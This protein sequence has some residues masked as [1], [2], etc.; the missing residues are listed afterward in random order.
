MCFSGGGG[1]NQMMQMYLQQQQADQQAALQRELSDKQLAAQRD[2]SD[3]Q[4]ASNLEQFNYQKGLADQQQRQVTEQAGR[5]S[6][7]DTGRAQLL[8]EGAQKVNDAFA[9]FGDDYFNKYA[10]DYMGKVGD[11]L[12]YQEREAQKQVAF[13]AARQGIQ[14]S[15]AVANQ[16]GLLAETKGRTLAE[17]TVNA[18]N[19]VGALKSRVAA[20]RQNLLGQ[21]T[22]AESIG[23]PIAAADEPGVQSQLQTQRNAVSGVANTAGDT[24]SSLN[25]VPTVNTL[26]NIFANVIGSAGSYLGGVQANQTAGYLKRGLAGTNP[27]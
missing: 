4:A 23:S 13:G 22:S 7:Y 12:G 26:S 21:V 5:Q 18:Q 2:I 6:A 24:V 20:A 15:Q 17:E 1:G 25:A 9:Q 14:D 3:R 8:G 16:Q 27:S 11:Q 10:Q 19:Q